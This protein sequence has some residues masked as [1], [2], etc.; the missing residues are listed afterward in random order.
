MQEQIVAAIGHDVRS[1]LKF[2]VLANQKIY[3]DLVKLNTERALMISKEAWQAANKTYHHVNNFVEFARSYLQQGQVQLTPVC[4]HEIVSEKLDF[5]GPVAKERNI[6]INNKVEPELKVLSDGQLLS[7]IVHNLL[8]NA[9]KYARKGN[10]EVYTMRD[11]PE[12]HLV[13]ADEGEGMGTTFVDRLNLPPHQYIPELPSP[14][15]GLGLMMVRELAAALQIQ[16]LVIIRT[17]THIHLIFA[18]RA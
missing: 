12:I 9:I 8:D 4:L 5:F 10:I 13:I 16:L 18:A 11:G 7:V 14:S 2:M 17:G 1:P 15:R 6:R 3:E